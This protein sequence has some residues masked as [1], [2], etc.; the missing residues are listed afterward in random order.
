MI[1]IPEPDAEPAEESEYYDAQVDECF[2]H[3]R[4]DDEGD[5]QAEP[6]WTRAQREVE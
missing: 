3:P 5:E 6:D 1:L 4:H 2:D